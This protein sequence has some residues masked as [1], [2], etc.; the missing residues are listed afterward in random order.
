MK[1]FILLTLLIFLYLPH[2]TFA[3]NPQIDSLKATLTH[4]LPN[5]KE[6]DHL[7]Q[8]GI[9]YKST[10]LDSSL[11]YLL[12]AE[13]AFALLKNENKKGILKNRIALV[14]YNKGDYEQALAYAHAS[15]K[16]MAAASDYKSAAK[17]K[18]TIGIT[19]TQQGKYEE[20]WEVLSE[21]RDF[22]QSA[23][24]TLMLSFALN[25]LAK[26]K[27]HSGKIS[28]AIDYFYQALKLKEKLG[29]Q[30]GLANA[31]NNIGSLYTANADHEKSIPFFEKAIEI[32]R[33]HQFKRSEASALGNLGIVYKALEKKEKALEVF[34]EGIA[35]NQALGDKHGEAFNLI[36][37]G[38]LHVENADWELGLQY[39]KE[40]ESIC[41]TI[42]DFTLFSDV[43][44]GLGMAHHHIGQKQKAIDYYEKSLAYTDQSNEE[45][46][47]FL[48]VSD[49]AILYAETGN[50]EQAYLFEKKAYELRDSIFS[51]DKAEKT[52]ELQTRYETE[53][54]EAELIKQKL[55]IAQ[56]QNV[57][58]KLIIGGIAGLLFLL[59][60]FQYFRN[61]QRFKRQ[62]VELSVKL[63]QAKSNKLRELDQ[64]KS[65][66]FANI[67]HEFRTPL[68]LILSPI[69]QMLDGTLK[70]NTEYWL[71]NMERNGRR[72][73]NLVN[74]LLD[75]SR[76][77]SGKMDVHKKTEDA[78]DIFKAMTY[79]FES[80]AESRQINYYIK[81]PKSLV[82]AELDRDKVEKIL[83]NL[84]S[85]AFKFS[86]EGGRIEAR[87]EVLEGMILFKISDTGPGIPEQELPHVFE[88]FF[89]TEGSSEY[90]VGSGIGLAL[91][92]EL[93][94]LHGGKIEV[95]SKEEEGSTFSLYLPVG[96]PDVSQIS[97]GEK[98]TPSIVSSVV[99]KKI[100][101]ESL[102][103]PLD[104]KQA[105]LLLVEDNPD[106]SHYIRAQFKDRYNV[107][108]AMDGA[109]GLQKAI[110]TTPDLIISDVMMPKMDG[111]ELCKHL[112]TNEKTSHIPVIMLTA[113]AEQNDKLV[114]LETGA[115]AYVI[116]PFDPKELQIRV[117]KLIEQRQQ[118]REKFSSDFN[119]KPNEIAVNSTDFT[120]LQN[121]KTIIENHIGDELFGVPELSQA[122]G[123]SRSQL[124]RKLSALT[125]KS[126]SQL[127]R[128]MRLY[129][130]KDLLEQKAG[131]ASEVAYRCGFSSPAQFSKSFKKFFGY[132]PSEVVK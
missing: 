59:G 23:K 19:L 41:L 48:T 56:Q 51:L 86:E 80:L 11:F 89:Q 1:N 21:V 71:R 8:I 101:K 50:F 119:F 95:S 22:F 16:I 90:G 98:P 31:Y 83:V 61:H 39:L 53:K 54:K 84:L 34:S 57:Q 7:M 36:N 82:P 55:I 78:V 3:Q 5:E 26:V 109:E 94:E 12:K 125:D 115:D 107:T 69:R 52:A 2:H 68:T 73:L 40:A 131:N 15:Q 17:A 18:N 35:V 6:A 100:V 37:L 105:Q 99:S 93:A 130:A 92:K 49:L 106:L 27:Y 44:N 10:S 74:Q 128:E 20:A 102:E 66:F 77:E 62:Q 112:K 67:S 103:L 43:Y 9:L 104:N 120:F 4:A 116:K 60:I 14:Y 117:E 42:N 76:L 25:N 29:D 75:L 96:S 110:D 114:G 13:Q 65:S 58:N 30:Y 124:H 47:E 85:N 129:R 63:E 81:H 88:R 45:Y 127:I 32:S 91:S 121:V 118:L 87:M 70:G 38:R 108:I 64:M 97:F 24:D 122:I 126:A 72:L 111:I 123:F 33:L 113:K 79:S 132:S 28:E 46:S